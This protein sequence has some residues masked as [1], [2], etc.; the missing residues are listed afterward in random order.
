[1]RKSQTTKSRFT[2]DAPGRNMLAGGGTRKKYLM[3]LLVELE[4]Y[5]L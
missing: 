1:M 2:R 3:L 4:V 5:I